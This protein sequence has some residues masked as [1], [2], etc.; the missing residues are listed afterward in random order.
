[1]HPSLVSTHSAVARIVTSRADAQ[2]LRLALIYALLDG[3]DGIELPHLKA[4]VALWDYCRASAESQFA[5][6]T[7][8]L[9]AK[10]LLDAL[11]HRPFSKT[12]LHALL[13][14]HTP[15]RRLDAEL[16]ELIAQGLVVVDMS[17]TGGRSR[18]TYLIAEKIEGSLSATSAS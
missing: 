3:S 10:R 16:Q 9:L 18:T 12:E 8:S 4:A 14:N 6:G 13:H 17:K 1:M 11:R 15:A 5:S 2:V 7:E